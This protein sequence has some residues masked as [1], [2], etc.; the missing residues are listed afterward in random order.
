VSNVTLIHE[1]PLEVLR[2]SPAAVLDLL[3]VA[4]LKTPRALEVESL[5]TELAD[6]TPSVRR[7]DFVALLKRRKN[8]RPY[9]V[10]IVEVQ[11]E[12]DREKP[13]AWAEYMAHLHRKHGVEVVLVVMVFDSRVARWARTSR[14]VGPNMIYKP[15]AIGPRSFPRI[16][17]IDQALAHPS[18]AVLTALAHLGS[19]RANSSRQSEIVRV[20]E[21]M[22]R[23]EETRFRRTCLSL[24]HGVARNE[25]RS[26]LEGL[27][28]A[29][30]MGAL[31][32][33]R[34]EGEAEGL[35]K[36]KAL[37]KAEGKAEGA[38]E[39]RATGLLN[40]LR[41]RAIPVDSTQEQRILATRD[42]AAL[43]RWLLRALNATHI[44]Q[45]LD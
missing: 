29:F 14:R 43:D 6:A 34:A 16:T 9:R 42:L 45:V 36:G 22:L 38:A 3:R 26:M 1:A 17:S 4:G 18:L 19:R 27:M 8:G 35:L 30:G 15:F 39:G 10:V 20:F 2:Q 13:A 12:R 5:D 31:D 40:V 25:I 11:R 23:T 44:G 24:L 41:A 37:G 33:I 21:A 7:A 28:E 32:L